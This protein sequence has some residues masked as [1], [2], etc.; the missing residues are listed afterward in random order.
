MEDKMVELARFVQVSKAEM[1]A[2]LL[3]SEGIDCYVRDC[4]MNQIYSGVDFGGVKVELLEKDLQR[5]TE[6]MHDYGYGEN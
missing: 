6:I 3:E 1:L 2:N 4:F 5:A